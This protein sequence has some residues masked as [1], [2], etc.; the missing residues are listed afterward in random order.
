MASLKEVKQRISSVRS[1]LHITSA[2]KM[3]SAAKL[4]HAQQAIQGMHPYEEKLHSIL[5]D[6]L[7]SEEVRGLG[8]SVALYTQGPAQP[9]Q[10]EEQA[11]AHPRLAIVVFSSNSSLCGSFNAN[12]IKHFK[13]LVEELSQQGYSNDEMD[14]YA[15]GKKVATVV[16]KQ[17]F[18]QKEDFS[19][20]AEHPNYAEASALGQKLM[21][22]YAERRIGKVILLYNH[23]A[24]NSSQPTL[25]QT[26]LPLNLN[27][28]SFF[29]PISATTADAGEQ[30]IVEPSASDLIKELLPKVL[31]QKIYTVLVDANA[32]EHAARTVAMQIASDN[33]EKLLDE[34]TLEYNKTRQ[35][36][37][38]SEILDLVGGLQR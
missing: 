2:M 10:E 7:A 32:A 5:T 6:L 31:L 20:L 13:A 38:T 37:I 25:Q 35:Q 14:V 34:L 3:V 33:A 18:A 26:W 11:V 30:L 19:H 36:K 22:D 17:G 23:Y 29:A 1:T 24:S 15:I 27:D 21:T 28:S 4:H 9:V 8:E 16:R 12:V